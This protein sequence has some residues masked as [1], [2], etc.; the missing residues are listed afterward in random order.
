MKTGKNR[1]IV[2]SLTVALIVVL[3]LG[4]A[5]TQA[6]EE[7]ADSDARGTLYLVDQDWNGQLVTTAVA[8]I[9]LEQE[10]DHTVATKFAPADSAPLFIGLETGDFHWVCCNWPSYSAAL[11]EE[12]VDASDAEVE[13][14]GS[15][16]IKGE[17]GWYVPSYVIDGDAERGIEPAAPDLKTVGDLNNYTSVFA[18]S[19]T[20]DKGRLL[21]FTA[22]W[23]TRPEERLD[24]FGVDFQAVFA[25]SEGAALAQ[26]DA[27]FQRGEPVLTYLWEPHWAHAK[28]NLV[29][30]EMPE[31]SSDCYPDG[32]S[33]N[34][35]FPTD[36][37]A[38]LAWPGLKDEFPEAYEFLSR[39]QMTNEQQ[40]EIVLNL[41]ENDLTVR[42]AAQEWVDANEAI[43]R[44]WIP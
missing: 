12:Y 36:D 42:Q 34:C 43:W 10:M 11:L 30:L 17:T 25:G 2:L 41:T 24:A 26:V 23:D 18:T 20:G 14:M 28:Y 16:G 40:N 5:C 32:S 19:D 6:A 22:A 8:Q 27:A 29:Q 13:R 21:E 4:V 3:A 39:F 15:V 1:W 31:W 9:L 35:G 7:S 38:K 37:V 44:P 33:Y